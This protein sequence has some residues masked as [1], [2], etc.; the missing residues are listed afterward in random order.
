MPEPYAILLQL[1]RFSM[2][3]SQGGYEDQPHILLE[4]LNAAAAAENEFNYKQRKNARI[5]AEFEAAKRAKNAK[6]NA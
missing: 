2:S 3:W 4:E 5:K 6:N 1:R